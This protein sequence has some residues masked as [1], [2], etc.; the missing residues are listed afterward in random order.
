MRPGGPRDHRGRH[1]KPGSQFLHLHTCPERLERCHNRNWSAVLHDKL[2]NRDP[3]RL[4]SY[5]NL[6]LSFRVEDDVDAGAWV[7]HR[8]ILDGTVNRMTVKF[9]CYCHFSIKQLKRLEPFLILH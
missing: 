7:F 2:D 6:V 9:K 1:D 4:E 5:S 8:L 3:V